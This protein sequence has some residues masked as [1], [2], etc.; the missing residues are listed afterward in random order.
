MKTMHGNEV[1]GKNSEGGKRKEIRRLRNYSDYVVEYAQMERSGATEK[2]GRR[3]RS[4][5]LY[6]SYGFFC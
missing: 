2:V 3:E 5:Y 4:S 6:M 1:N